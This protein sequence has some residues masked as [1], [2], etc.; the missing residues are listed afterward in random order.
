MLRPARRLDPSLT[1]TVGPGFSSTI[2][3]AE[4]IDTAISRP[5][6]GPQIAPS[7]VSRASLQAEMLHSG[8]GTKLRLH[9]VRFLV[10]IF[11]K[12]LN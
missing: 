6:R 4:M 1:V 8:S 10:Q 12:S 11:C 7:L 2:W 9:T 5:G 3:A